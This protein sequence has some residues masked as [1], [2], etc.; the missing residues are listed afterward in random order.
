MFLTRKCLSNAMHGIKIFGGQI[1]HIWYIFNICFLHV[2][3][4]SQKKLKFSQM[5][6]NSN[7][8][9]FSFLFISGECQSSAASIDHSV[10]IG[11]SQFPVD[12]C[13]IH[14]YKR[15]PSKIGKKEQKN[16]RG[17]RE[18]LILLRLEYLCL[19]FGLVI[20]IVLNH[21]EFF[22]SENQFLSGQINPINVRCSKFRFTKP[23][24]SIC[25]SISN[26]SAIKM[27]HEMMYYQKIYF[28]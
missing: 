12:T 1:I 11:R 20:S 22:F 6:A 8:L 4:R 21:W 18:W 5:H 28:F 15:L 25:L 17:D 27:H 10:P 19:N 16:Q 3:H 2:F 26:S 14:Q 7:L 9:F 13:I 24:S 23:K